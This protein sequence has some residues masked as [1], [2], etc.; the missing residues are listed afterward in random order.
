MQGQPQPQGGLP[1]KIP[2][3]GPAN[4]RYKTT[5]CKHYNTPQGCS[6]GEKC[7]FA[8]GNHELRLNNGQ[9]GNVMPQGYQ[10]FHN[11]NQGHN[12]K[13]A[14]GKNSALNYKIVKC[15][16]WERDQTCKY[17]AH[18]T[19][20]HGDNDLRTK[21]ENYMQMN[22]PVVMP[23]IY[24]INQMG[25]M[26]MSMGTMPMMM[27]SGMDMQQMQQMMAIQLQQSQ[28]P[29]G[30]TPINSQPKQEDKKEEKP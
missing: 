15:K 6:Y 20:A 2:L 1:N 8:H 29:V 23:M 19:F 17:G 11:K 12:N 16:N 21:N 4:P 13:N 5:L 3:K 22:A 14:N 28:I 24:D 30:M 18:C 7:Q 27:P 9:G 26:P 10:N 25:N